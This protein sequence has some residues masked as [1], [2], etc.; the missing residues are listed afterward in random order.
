MP[1]TQPPDRVYRF[2]EFRLMA[3]ERIL[4]RGDERIPMAPRIFEL[5]L[6]LVENA[7]R[8][9]TKESLLNRI[10][11]DSF[12][13][14]GNL[15]QTVS[16][17]RKTLG[18]RPNENRFIET[19]PRVGYRFIADVELLTSE[20]ALRTAVPT[21]AAEPPAIP[22][23]GPR[24][25][26]IYMLPIVVVLAGASAAVWWTLFRTRPASDSGPPSKQVPVRL[27]V[28][29]TREDAPVFT[30]EG[31]IRFMRWEGDQ[32]YAY[33]MAADG[34]NQRRET[35]LAQLVTGVWSPDGKKVVFHK[36]GDNSG[37]RYIADSN[38]ENEKLLPFSPGNMQWSQ[39]GAKI[40]YQAGRPNSDIFV[41]DVATN[42]SRLFSGT[43]GFESDPSFSPDGKSVVF[44]SDRDGNPEIYIQ[45]LEGTNLRRLTNHPAHDEFPTFSPDG[46]QIV[47]NSNREDEN[48]D[49][50][51]MNADGTRVRR[52]TNWR[53]DEE[54]RPG[55]WSADG[56]RLVLLSNR[57]GRP[58]VYVMDVEPYAPTLLLS[59]PDR[60]LRS[61]TFSPNGTEIAFV[62][63]IADG[64]AELRIL[65]LQT[66]RDELLVKLEDAS[67]VARY[68]PDGKSL[69]VQNRINGN[70]EICLIAGS[71]GEMRNLTNDP[72][73]DVH[74]DWSP[75][76]TKI[77]F[78]SNRLGN[79]DVFSIF[80]MNADGSNPHRIYF[81]NAISDFPSWSPDGS[82]IVF[83][84]DK[85]DG[86]S[87]NF[88]IF[89]IEPET[90]KQETRLT[91]RPRADVHAAFSPD[92]RR[93][94][95]ASRGDGNFEIYVMN[96]DGTSQ[97]RLTRDLS[98]DLSPAWS[99]DGKRLVFS[100]NRNG[101]FALYE[102]SLD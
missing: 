79:Y 26:L 90:V 85:E 91:F 88:E 99:P 51:L 97:L 100:R 5:L 31:D 16:R 38:G 46:T 8:L 57:D 10:W 18:E 72:S 82:V 74:P 48:F 47:F 49:I 76:G 22:T 15:N 24:R 68:S 11:E 43:P 86:R 64:T 33:I 40:V 25:L 13:E 71:G 27:T 89:A 87:G 19:V 77:V 66:R 53:S 65:D 83:S 50:Y 67:A 96:A 6:A 63:E 39:D 30:R 56:T 81:S 93:I 78:V 52:L 1:A 80:T 73:R 20:E 45:D 14:E 35:A 70:T 23:A 101:K 61:P 3:D 2:G 69:L 12:V 55:C 44:T 59:T 34:S 28:N 75:D 37:A 42:E 98:E 92:G 58:N 4:L 7:G 36:S 94:A 17:L 32:P 62:S 29:A 9:V 95:F 84:N 54:I 102:L 21:D 60:D 41:Y